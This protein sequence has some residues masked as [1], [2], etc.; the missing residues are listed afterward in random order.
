MPASAFFQKAE[1]PFTTKANV[2]LSA[3]CAPAANAIA[4]PRATPAN[5]TFFMQSS[6]YPYARDHDPDG[7]CAYA[8]V[9]ELPRRAECPTTCAAKSYL[10][11]RH[12]RI[13]ALR[14]TD[15][16]GGFNVTASGGR[17]C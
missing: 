9:R 13:F 2:F 15:G 10:S 7:R 11:I 17:Q 5:S 6:L 8:A 3:A 4:R 1:A 16:R 12:K 14:S